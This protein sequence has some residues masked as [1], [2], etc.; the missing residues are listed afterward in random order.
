MLKRVRFYHKLSFC[1][2]TF[3]ICSVFEKWW[4]IFWL[5]CI[6]SYLTYCIH[7]TQRYTYFLLCVFIFVASVWHRYVITQWYSQVQVLRFVLLNSVVSCE[8]GCFDDFTP[9]VPASTLHFWC[10]CYFHTYGSF[11]ILKCALLPSTRKY[12]IKFFHKCTSVQSSLYFKCLLFKCILNCS[13]FR[14]KTKWFY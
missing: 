5:T 6:I 3:A 4:I 11:Y 12:G 8:W 7:N 1:S 10:L 13:Y 2:Q 9:L 14:R